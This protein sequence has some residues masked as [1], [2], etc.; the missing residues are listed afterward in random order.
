MKNKKIIIGSIIVFL[1]VMGIIGVM[2]I[3]TEESNQNVG[4]VENEIT[5]ARGN[6]NVIECM[7]HI[8]T[9]NTVEELNHIIGFEAEKSKY[10]EEYKWELDSK[11]FIML[12][13]A[14]DSPII[15]ATIDKETIKSET[16]KFPLMSELQGMLN[17]GSFTYEELVEKLG[18]VEGTLSGK[19]TT[20]VGYTWVDKHNQTLS[21][22]F[23]KE[24]GKCTIASYR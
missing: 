20:S 7:K 10:S 17:N 11:N 18:G 22:T 12:K 14:G 21:A 16:V 6:Y 23:N 8:E 24:S 9:S 19:S 4:K 5:Q 1:I 15:Q 2:L 13:Y 3:G